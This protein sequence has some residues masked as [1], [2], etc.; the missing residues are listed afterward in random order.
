MPTLLLKTEKDTLALGRAL[1][2]VANA[3]DVITLSG[4]LGA[5]KTVLARGFITERAG[6]STDIASPTF[7]LAHVYDSV[8]PPIWHFDFYRIE[9]PQDVEE[10][11]LDDALA[12]GIS[13]I[14]W[15]DRAKAWLPSERLD[16]E[17]ASDVETNARRATL[18]A[19]PQWTSRL[20]TLVA[21]RG[22]T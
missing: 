12:G 16:I 3:G 4:P 19:S 5:G 22:V 17:L 6:P 13:V 1:A 11:G 9:A 2:R 7:T 14:E 21:E 20:D 15:P 10:L 8:T 18:S